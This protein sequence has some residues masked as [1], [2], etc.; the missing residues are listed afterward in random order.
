MLSCE[1][2]KPRVLILE[3]SADIT[4]ALNS[5][6]RSTEALC[7]SFQFCFVLPAGSKAIP[8]LQQKGFEVH[9]LPMQGDTQNHT[10]PGAIRSVPYHQYP[11]I[12]PAGA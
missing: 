7:D 5:I 2:Q 6:L 1:M 3:N 8:A 9:A 11:T 12:P 10:R 4:G